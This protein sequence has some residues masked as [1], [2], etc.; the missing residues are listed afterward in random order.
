MTEQK[1]PEQKKSS[2]NRVSWLRV[3]IWALGLAAWVGGVLFVSQYLVAKIFVLILPEYLLT[4][5]VVNGIYSVIVYAVCMVLTIG[6]PWWFLKKKTTRDELGL[7]GLPTWADLLI[8]PIGFA[9]VMIL[10]SIL[11][12]IMVAILPS[13]DWQQTQDVGFHGLYNFGE[14]LIAFICLVLLAPICEEII[15]RGWLYGKLRVRL[16]AIPAMLIVSVL[17]GIM[18]GQWNVG[19]T[20]FAMSLGMCVMREFTG[21]IWAGV[22]LHMIKNGIAFYALFI[23][24]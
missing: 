9:A 14:H 7:R 19:V 6:L 3:A 22:I 17:F 15:F 16:P 11:M 21:T 1:K 18:H 4:N 20:V 23:M 12:A 24:M 8:A 13:V 2:R 10:A 5:N